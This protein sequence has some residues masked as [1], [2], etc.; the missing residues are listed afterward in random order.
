MTIDPELNIDELIE[1]WTNG[2]REY[3]LDILENEHPAVAA[4]VAW[5]MNRIHS[6][7]LVQMLKDRRDDKIMEARP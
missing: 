5:W 1:S 3:V 6:Q 4:E 2:N 7:T